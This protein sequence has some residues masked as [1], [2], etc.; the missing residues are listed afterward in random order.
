[1]R[2]GR[3]RWI[4]A[5]KARPSRHDFVKSVTL[6]SWYPSVIR[7]HHCCKPFI[8]VAMVI[9]K[10]HSNDYHTTPDQQFLLLCQHGPIVNIG[11]LCLRCWFTADGEHVEFTVQFHFS[12]PSLCPQFFQTDNPARRLPPALFD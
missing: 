12:V 3:K 1:M 7:L 9:A 4:M 10:Q 11:S 2:S 6:T 8:F 5:Q